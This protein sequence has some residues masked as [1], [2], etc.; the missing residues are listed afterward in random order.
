MKM[1]FPANWLTSDSLGELI[2]SELRFQIINGE[3]E[4]GA[5]LSENMISKSFETSRISS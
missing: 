4:D 5:V 1:K 3:I 2:S